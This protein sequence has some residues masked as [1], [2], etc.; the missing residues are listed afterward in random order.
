MLKYT[1]ITPLTSVSQ[2]KFHENQI[3]N[4]FLIIFFE[5]KYVVLYEI[6]IS[7]EKSMRQYFWSIIVFKSETELH[8]FLTNVFSKHDINFMHLSL[9]VKFIFIC[10]Q[11]LRYIEYN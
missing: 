10:F 9:N 8:P 1:K 2:K 7:W 5:K 3:E 6:C 11:V 4:D